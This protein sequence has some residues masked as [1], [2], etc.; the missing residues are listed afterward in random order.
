VVGSEDA[1]SGER[2]KKRGFGSGRLPHC[3]STDLARSRVST[4]RQDHLQKFLSHRYNLPWHDLPRS[5][6]AYRA[7]VQ[8]IRSVCARFCAPRPDGTP[9]RQ[10]CVSVYWYFVSKL[11]CLQ[12]ISFANSEQT[13]VK[14]RFILYK[15]YTD[16]KTVQIP[17]LAT[18]IPVIRTEWFQVSRSRDCRFRYP[19]IVVLAS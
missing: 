12:V 15:H 16:L 8:K 4:D 1:R 14:L 6:K 18:P 11:F 3:S 17:P 2:Q 5:V 13:C 19:L 10:T 9:R 7:R